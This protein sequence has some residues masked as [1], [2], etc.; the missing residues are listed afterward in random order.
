MFFGVWQRGGDSRGICWPVTELKTFIVGWRRERPSLSVWK[1]RQSRGVKSTKSHEWKLPRLREDR[2]PGRGTIAP[3]CPVGVQRKPESCVQERGKAVQQRA[4]AQRQNAPV[5]L[6]QSVELRDGGRWGNWRK[7]TAGR[8]F[9]SRTHQ[10]MTTF[11]RGIALRRASFQIRQPRSG[12]PQPLR[13]CSQQKIGRTSQVRRH[14]GPMMCRNNLKSKE[15][16]WPKHCL[17]T[18]LCS[19][20][21][22]NTCSW[23]GLT[24]TAPACLLIPF[25][26]KTVFWG[27]KC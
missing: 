3:S 27:K 5:I 23:T 24:S 9:D 21:L 1:W 11:W 17:H 25:S 6:R 19:W 13:S 15:Q 20:P 16:T 7:Q 14:W 2:R 18:I 12:L 4:K 8:W 10:R 26:Q 22:L